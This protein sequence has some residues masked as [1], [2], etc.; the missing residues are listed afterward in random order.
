MNINKLTCFKAYDIRSPIGPDLNEDIFYRI[1]R[2][3]CEHL[4]AKNIVIGHDARA[5]SPIFANILKNAS[6]D[7]DVNVLDIGLAG[8]EEVYWAVKEF[9]ASA[10]MMVTAS[11]NPINYNGIKIVK[12]GSE[13]LDSKI[14]FQPI[15][16]ITERNQFKSINQKGSLYDFKTSARQ[17]YTEKIISFVDHR[18]LKPL[19][20][21]VNSGNGAAGPSFDRIVKKLHTLGVQTNFVLVNHNPDSNFPKGVPNPLLKENQRET[22]FEIIKNKA[23]FGVAFDGDFDR[24]FFF[25]ETGSF[26]SGEQIVALIASIFISKEQGARV[27]HDGRVIW[28]ISEK[29]KSNQGISII[30]KVG[31]NFMKQ[32]MRENEAIYGGEISAHHYFRDFAYCDSGMIPFL[33]L[34]EILSKSKTTFSRLINNEK[35]K[36]LSSGEINFTVEDPDMCF[37][38][39]REYYLDLSNNYTEFDGL[40]FTFDK[41]RF[42]VRKSNTEP[43]IRLNIETKGSQ[44]ILLQKIEELSRI[45]KNVSDTK[46]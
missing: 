20:I 9:R 35:I 11:H 4:R 2:A 32:A 25:D 40:S 6:L 30:A 15:K 1:G 21:V 45:I 26:V 34:W 12:Y 28:N 29:I 39:I 22:S 46:G 24:C 17:K 33:I 13:P 10:G 14:D 8:T 7:S 3:V 37:N 42:N 31:H 44:D 27:V 43:L 5:T 38:L 36:F 16:K 41:W 19:K 23:D 18:S